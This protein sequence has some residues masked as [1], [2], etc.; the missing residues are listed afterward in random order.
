MRRSNNQLLIFFVLTSLAFL[1]QCSSD[2]N[3]FSEKLIGRWV[4]VSAARDGKIT[5][6][7]QDAFFEFS[8][9]GKVSFNLDGTTQN[10]TYALSGSKFSIK[11][12]SMDA[13]Y[14]IKEK[15]DANSL[16]LIAQI[17]GYEFKFNLSKAE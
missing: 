14:T 1:T 6:T 16:D 11:G 7:L 9:D 15:E 8:P 12:S 10:A 2:P 5:N 17:R 13:E 4:V 3:Q